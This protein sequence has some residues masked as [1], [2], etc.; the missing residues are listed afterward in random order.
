M[1]PSS[2][3]S[4]SAARSSSSAPSPASPRSSGLAVLSLLYF[5]Q[6]REVKRLREWAGRAPERAAELQQR[7]RRDAARRAAAR[8]RRPRDAAAAGARAPAPARR[9]AGAP[10]PGTA[11]RAS[12]RRG[13]DRHRPPRRRRDAA[14]AGRR[15]P[16]PAPALPR[17]ARRRRPARP[18]PRTGAPPRPAA[19]A[20]A[21]P[22]RDGR[23]APVRP[24]PRPPAVRR[25]CHG[26]RG[27]AP[28][29]RARAARSSR[30]RL[31]RHGGGDA[32]TAR[33]DERPPRG[34]LGTRPRRGRRRPRGSPPLAVAA[35]AGVFG[36]GDDPKRA[37]PGPPRRR[38][39]RPPDRG[40]PGDSGALRHPGRGP[41]RHHGHRA[42]PQVADRL[43]SR[44]YPGRHVTNAADQA[45]QATVVAY[46][47]GLR[48]A[49]PR[50]RQDPRHPGQPGRAAG[51]QHQQVVAGADADVVVT[52]GADQAQ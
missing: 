38:P 5:A 28:R 22:A 47:D 9:A 13:A 41:Q 8:R 31:A 20:A 46:A 21:T 42:G 48:A 7:G 4:R 37:R 39:A 36:G 44:G 50:R 27:R 43:S 11:R 29:R 16:R 52:V 35:R 33:R 49:G 10:A 14:R 26:G 2:S 15:A 25:T 18:P 32:A 17:P 51:R 6:A 30:R 23:A 40:R 24:A 19:P 3:P 45:Q 34:G 12:R 1:G